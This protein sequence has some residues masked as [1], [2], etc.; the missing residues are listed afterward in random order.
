MGRFFY[1]FLVSPPP[2]PPPPAAGAR[3]RDHQSW[4]RYVGMEE[5]WSL[6]DMASY[7]DILSRLHL[8][9][10]FLNQN[11]T[12][13]DSSRGNFCRYGMR[14]S[15][16]VYLAIRLWDGCVLCSNHCSSRGTSLTG[17]MNVRFRFRRSSASADRFR[18]PAAAADDT[19]QHARNHS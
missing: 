8:A 9:R 10:R 7:S 17:S 14:F 2:P 1:L 16:S 5:Y 4:L 15:S 19:C 3:R 12:F 11:C 18:P 6:G 13:L